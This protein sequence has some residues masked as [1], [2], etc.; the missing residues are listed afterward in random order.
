MPPKTRSQIAGRLEPA[1]LED[2][3]YPEYQPNLPTSPPAFPVDPENVASG[4]WE[5]LS[6]LVSLLLDTGR[7]PPTHLVPLKANLVIRVLSAKLTLYGLADC[8]LASYVAR[9]RSRAHHSLVAPGIQRI[10]FDKRA[11]RS[12]T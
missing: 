11:T 7:Q 4:I 1:A 9:T 5:L 6:A 3:R 2:G 8:T 10:A 12:L